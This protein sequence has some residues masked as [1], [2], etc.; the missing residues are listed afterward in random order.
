MKLINQ[1]KKIFVSK[2]SEEADP[3]FRTSNH[4]FHY[5]ELYQ[6][7]LVKQDQLKKLEEA[8]VEMKSCF[9]NQLTEEAYNAN[10]KALKIMR[11]SDE[12]I[13]Y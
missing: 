7:L 2:E 8:V 11:D 4:D 12:E 13:K 1:F 10:K 6:K 3:L 9:D 5:D